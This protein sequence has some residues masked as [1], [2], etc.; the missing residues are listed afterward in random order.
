VEGRSAVVLV[1]PILSGRGLIDAVR[2]RGHAA[3]A[4]INLPESLLGHVALPSDEECE[5]VLYE[6]EAERIAG[7]VRD[8]GYDV[9]AVISGVEPGVI[10]A[11]Q[12]AHR[13]GL[14]HN[15]LETL[16]ARRDKYEMKLRARAAGLRCARARRCFDE[17]DLASFAAEVGYPVVLKTPSGTA[18]IGVHRCDDWERLRAGFAAILSEPDLMGQRA[19]HALAEEYLRGGELVVD[20]FSDER[21]VR[22]TDLWEYRK[23][24]TAAGS[25]VYYDTVQVPP[26]HPGA[27]AAGDYAVALVAAL[28]VRYGA[29]HCEIKLTPEGPVMVELNARLAGGRLPE[30]M[31]KTSTFDPYE[32]TLDAY[33][34]GAARTEWPVRALRWAASAC[35]QIERAGRVRA[36]HGLDEILRLPSYDS[37][38][39][40]VQVGD[41][42][43]P[44]ESIWG[45]PLIV[46]L[47]HPER[48]VVARDAARVH[49]CF[50]L[51]VA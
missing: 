17:Q 9:R 5:L 48:E 33:L 43:A 25:F 24:E 38:R 23:L 45:V 50:A 41:E 4:V 49:A 20:T 30:M 31:R 7:L 42:V 3:V 46:W 19:D 16:A 8:R 10:L 35:C 32:A 36:I 14:R 22:V 39:L 47:A 18:S 6:R 2:R 11:D 26:S 37:H 51:E 1:D 12:L 13:L 21:G 27:A 15:E 44:T 34:D 28:G 40:T 29:A